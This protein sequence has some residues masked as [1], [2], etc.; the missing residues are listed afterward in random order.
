MLL[1][2][3][4]GSWSKFLVL[5][6]LSMSIVSPFSP[7]SIGSTLKITYKLVFTRENKHF[8]NKATVVEVTTFLKESF[9]W[10]K[11]KQRMRALDPSKS[12]RPDNIHGIMLQNLGKISLLETFNAS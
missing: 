8:E 5:N 9:I 10:R 1:K 2:Q 12:P 11:W 7:E 6:S 4:F 3:D